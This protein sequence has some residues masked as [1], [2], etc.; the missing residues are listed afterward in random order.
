MKERYTIIK[1]IYPD[2]LIL[3]KEKDKMIYYKEDKLIVDLFGIKNLNNV[4]KI[5]LNNLDIEKIE[6]YQY[7]EYEIYYSKCKLINGLMEAINEE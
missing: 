4:N 1:K 2:Y 5:I 7:N 3:F 6:K